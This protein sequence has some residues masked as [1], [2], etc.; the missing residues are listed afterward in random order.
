MTI[1]SPSCVVASR[2][3]DR[4]TVVQIQYLLLNLACDALWIGRAGK[5]RPE[6]RALP[7][8]LTGW[9][10]LQESLLQHAEGEPR[11]HFLLWYV[12]RTPRM[13]NISFQLSYVY[14]QNLLEH[15]REYGEMKTV[16][17]RTSTSSTS[18]IYSLIEYD[19]NLGFQ[20]T[21]IQVSS[22]TV[23][24]WLFVRFRSTFIQTSS[25]TTILTSTD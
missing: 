14:L 11:G 15:L 13:Y 3:E 5:R 21:T 23:V 6:R 20:C 12:L 8:R 16:T 25:R 17:V 18:A 7:T 22:V 9:Q 2:L 1:H 4:S 24:R 10:P 19:V